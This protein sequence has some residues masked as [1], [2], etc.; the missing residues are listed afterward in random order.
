LL[1]RTNA[2]VN[3]SNAKANVGLQLRRARKSLGL[4]VVEAAQTIDVAESELLAWERGIARPTIEQLWVLADLYHRGSDYFLKDIPALPEAATFRSDLVHS[5]QDLP[6]PAKLALVRFDELCRA[7]A[8]LEAA[9]GE[10]R[11]VTFRRDHVDAAPDD[12]A[13]TERARLGLGDSPIRDLRATL[14]ETGVRV[15][16]LPLPGLPPQE[17]SGLSWWH[18]EYGPCV[19]VNGR[20][21]VGRRAF[22]LAHEYAHLLRSGDAVGCGFMVETPEERYANRFASNFL[23]PETSVAVAF[24][25]TVGVPH[26]DPTDYQLGS[27]A[28][29]FG[30]SLEAMGWRLESMH[31]VRHGFT[32]EQIERWEAR[33]FRGRGARGPRWRK[34]LGEDFVS[35]AMAA[36]D[37]G[38]VSSAKLAKYFG[39]DIRQTV[40]AL[41]KEENQPSG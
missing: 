19:L 40:D 1:K 34:Q 24:N 20:N 21:N 10:H 5:I 12:L 17:L 32:S 23:M 33:P 7:S 3:E 41:R 39:L 26:T 13:R 15:F 16:V 37:S 38:Q 9:V 22:T 35:L 6:T 14:S 4:S 2:A 31:L 27:L 30:V 11:R 36:Y 8:N 28:S 29:R 25:K 18:P